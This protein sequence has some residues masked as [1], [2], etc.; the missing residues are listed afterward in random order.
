LFYQKF[1]SALKHCRDKDKK[2]DGLA[3]EEREN[4]LDNDKAQRSA[5]SISDYNKYS[6]HAAS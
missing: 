2:S 5:S 3:D 6:R 1:A 4:Y